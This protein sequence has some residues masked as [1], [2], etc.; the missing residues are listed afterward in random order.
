MPTKPITVEFK[1]NLN[2][3]GSADEFKVVI[4]GGTK[5]DGTPD[6]VALDTVRNAVCNYFNNGNY[7]DNTIPTHDRAPV[8]SPPESAAD[9]SKH[10]IMIHPKTGE[11]SIA[12]ADIQDFAIKFQNDFVT[13]L[14]ESTAATA[15]SLNG[16]TLSVPTIAVDGGVPTPVAP[17]PAAPV[18]AKG[19]RYKLGTDN[20]DIFL[21]A[22]ARA[23]D[24]VAGERDR[25]K[26]ALIARAK[27]LQADA[28][29]V[30]LFGPGST[31]AIEQKH[32]EKFLEYNL[33]RLALLK[34]RLVDATAADK[35]DI[36][37]QIKNNLDFLEEVRKNAASATAGTISAD[38]IA[39]LKKP[40]DPSDNSVVLIPAG[41]TATSLTAAADFWAP[42]ASATA[43]PMMHMVSNP[44]DLAVTAT[45]ASAGT[46][47]PGTTQNNPEG[48]EFKSAFVDPFKHDKHENPYVASFNALVNALFH[49]DFY[50][51]LGHLLLR[52]IVFPVVMG[53]Y[54]EFASLG[55][56]LSAISVRP[57]N[58]GLSDRLFKYAEGQSRGG[59][60]FA[61]IENILSHAIT[62]NLDRHQLAGELKDTM[63]FQLYRGII[64]AVVQDKVFDLTRTDNVINSTIAGATSTVVAVGASVLL[65]YTAILK[66]IFGFSKRYELDADGKPVVDASGN[67]IFNPDWWKPWKLDNDQVQIVNVIDQ[68]VTNIFAKLGNIARF[69]VPI[70]TTGG[71][72]LLPIFNGKPLAT[73]IAGEPN[74]GSAAGRLQDFAYAF[75]QVK[76]TSHLGLYIEDTRNIFSGPATT[77]A[78]APARARPTRV[79]P[80][81]AGRFGK[82][83]SAITNAGQD[84]QYNAV[85]VWGTVVNGVTI[86][87]DE[88]QLIPTTTAGQRIRSV[89]RGFIMAVPIAIGGALFG[90]AVLAAGAIGASVNAVG[91]AIGAALSIGT[92]GILPLIIRTA[93]KRAVR[94]G[95]VA[96]GSTASSVRS[97]R[98]DSADSLASG[99]SFTLGAGAAPRQRVGSTASG[100]T[101]EATGS[102][103]RPRADSNLSTASGVTVGSTMRRASSAVSIDVSAAASASPAAGNTSARAAMARRSAAGLPRR[104]NA[105]GNAHGPRGLRFGFPGHAATSWF[106]ARSQA[107]QTAYAPP[108]I[109]GQGPRYRTSRFYG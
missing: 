31:A 25:K 92:L 61:P 83:M 34:D 32:R 82:F 102:M 45:P 42:A 56:R 26:Q 16:I 27:V 93:I 109:G 20:I 41:Y 51:T 99:V 36:I 98:S 6:F 84:A 47:G 69:V 75:F 46:R 77:G 62:G 9:G 7:F 104:I 44:A 15:P 5:D 81:R 60:I 89:R 72:I 54:A 39:D 30:A 38:L 40:V 107:Q 35:A 78:P 105:A 24:S 3:S 28:D 43:A 21:D 37:K 108:P 103:Q 19:I 48:Q 90:A 2:A 71:L 1:Y 59:I 33:I 50:I 86:Q 11:T 85:G 96:A 106:A 13:V 80:T 97:F 10:A 66:P 29:L 17:A 95:R 8:L 55:I 63:W 64:P 91:L 88:V 18:T 87:P 94:R 22:D 12:V 57:F 58:S 14:K 76:K 100:I 53:I 52:S 4:S 101:L 74:S 68:N 73:P 65:S 79:P 67:K 49:N 23:L 70:I